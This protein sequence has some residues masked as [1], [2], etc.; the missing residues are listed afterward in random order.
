MPALPIHH[1]ETPD[2]QSIPAIVDALGV[3]LE[4]IALLVTLAFLE[5]A[6]PEERFFDIRDFDEPVVVRQTIDSALEKCN[7]YL[8][9]P[10]TGPQY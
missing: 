10:L 3:A 5:P 1:L 2:L 9:L 7:A 6:F 8:F 4:D